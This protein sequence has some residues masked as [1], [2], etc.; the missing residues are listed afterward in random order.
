M[1]AASARGT[2]AARLLLLLL[3]ALAAAAPAVAS[4]TKPD[5]RNTNHNLSVNGPG[6][7]KAQDETQICVFCHTP[8]GAE[9][10]PGAPLWNRKINEAAGSYSRYDSASVNAAIPTDPDGSSKLCLSCHDGA[11]AI[12]TVGVLNGQTDASI[13]MA[14]GVTTMPGGSKGETSG[15]TRKLGVDLRN[16]H[17]ISF[18]YDSTLA[19]ADGELRDPP[20]AGGSTAGLVYRDGTVHASA[21]DKLPLEAG[22]VQCTTCHDPHIRD[23]NDPLKNIKFLRLNRFQETAPAGGDFNRSGDIVCIACHDKLGT[24]WAYSAHANDAVADEAYRLQASG[25][26][27]FP[28]GAK[29][30][31]AA[32]LNCH[33]THTV[34]GARRL[35]REGTDITGLSDAQ[36]QDFTRANTGLG[37]QGTSAIESTCYQCHTNGAYTVLE[38]ATDVPNIEDDF[39]LARRMPIGGTEVHDVTDADLSETR[40][41]L[42]YGNLDNRHAECT[43]CHNPHR[44]IRNRCFNG[45]DSVDSLDSA[46]STNACTTDGNETGSFP[47]PDGRGTHNHAAGHSNIASGVLRGTTGVEPDYTGIT[48]FYET[49][50]GSS[51][52]FLKGVGNSTDVNAAYVTREYQICLKCHSNYAYDDDIGLTVGNWNSGGRPPLGGAGLTPGIATER[53]NYDYY[54]NQA[55][56]FN[57]P[58][59]HQGAQTARGTEAGAH[60]NFNSGNHRSWHPVIRATGRPT[61]DR[62][63]MN[64]LAF[65]APW[66][67][68]IG[69]QTMYCTDCHGSNTAAGTAVP[70][71]SAPWGPHGSSNNFLLKG[72]WDTSTGS[73]QSNALCFK[74]H[75]S[76]RYGSGGGGTGFNTDKGDG[77][78]IHSQAR[79]LS[80]IRCNWC[81]VAVPHGWK[82]KALLA[83]LNDVGPEAGNAVGTEIAQS[84]NV[85][86]SVG[87]YYRNAM[88]KVVNFKS[89]TQWLISD[90]GSRSDS[91]NRGINWMK[92]NVCETPP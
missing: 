24:D 67:N 41:N 21:K 90:C 23:K 80:K 59:T 37:S 18:T 69:N 46:T 51:F 68:D 61:A 15:F 60:S 84:K 44:V 66:N 81:H 48:S 13:P 14:G 92:T 28:D 2:P 54:T 22:K 87:P 50:V 71:G 82:N 72:T 45:K 65:N 11:L 25:L 74:C 42:G 27:E 75:S 57:A 36:R 10:I 16:D 64:S 56:E 79:K 86:F 40:L 76:S 52:R 33:D 20:A 39:K 47:A 1:I 55:R 83:N 73:G 5:V 85:G 6:V 91:G 43:D 63:G 49:P 38:N 35:L 77:H 32:C 19:L 53:S 3:V 29:V 31:Q 70:S 8:H 30:W 89:D 58:A 4:E 78:E 9:S 12:N 7:V 17:P 34:N 62:N 88:L 26:R